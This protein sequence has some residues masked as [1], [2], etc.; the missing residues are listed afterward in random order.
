[1]CDQL[2][3]CFYALSH[4][5]VA[6]KGS[7]QKMDPNTN[8]FND[9]QQWLATLEEKGA[10]LTHI[11]RPTKWLSI[12][13]DQTEAPLD[14][15]L[16]LLFRTLIR[17]EAFMRSSIN[18]LATLRSIPSP[19]ESMA[20]LS[21]VIS[22][23]IAYALS[24]AQELRANLRPESN[25]AHQIVLH[26]IKPPEA[27]IQFLELIASIH[28]VHCLW[29]EARQKRNPRK[30]L[31]VQHWRWPEPEQTF[32][33]GVG[34]YMCPYV[35]LVD[36]LEKI[37]KLLTRQD[38]SLGRCR[39]SNL[40]TSRAHIDQSFMRCSKVLVLRLDLGF[41]AGSFEHP[42]PDK[43]PHPY[44]QS[45]VATDISTSKKYLARFLKKLKQLY[46]EDCLC[47]IVKTEYGVL[48]GFHFHVLIALNGH[49]RQQ[50]I[51]IVKRLGELWT[52]EITGGIGLY[53][54]CNAKKQNYAECGIGMIH[55]HDTAKRA[56]LE[57]KVLPYLIKHDIPFELM[58]GSG[59][60]RFQASCSM[61]LTA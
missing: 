47:Y 34:V 42:T 1:M 60:R 35:N 17:A 40:A 15:A 23:W 20:T 45:V 53:W 11:D 37:Q 26:R 19:K 10:L 58:K 56:F 48:K 44:Q 41:K 13:P 31:E 25:L 4:R 39:R 55:R 51:S 22:D 16:V 9:E 28:T 24:L 12:D 50:D 54:N 8:V 7:G 14:C 3:T 18:S 27:L 32:D 49:R 61:A 21:P 30:P 5:L 43:N 36:E 2:I 33:D 57:S 6:L 29:E 46:K 59:Y 52:A 38:S